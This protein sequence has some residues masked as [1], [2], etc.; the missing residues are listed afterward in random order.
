[1]HSSLRRALAPALAVVCAV[2]PT[3]ALAWN[4]EGHKQI[5]D[6]AWT[7]LRP[8]AK[9]AV[10]QILSAADGEFNAPAGDEAKAR[11]AFR[12]LATM[13]DVIKGSKESA[14]TPLAVEF[15]KT[16][17]PHPDSRNREQEL[18]KTWHYYDE[19][20][21]YSGA[22]PAI[23][24]SNAL[25]ALTKA[26][27][28]LADLSRRGDT[29]LYSSWWL[30]WIEHIVGDLHQPL[31][32]TSNY[33]KEREEGDAGGNKIHLGINGRNGRPLALHAYW[34]DGVDHAREAEGAGSR[35]AT[36]IEATTDRWS[37]DAKAQP[38]TARLRDL[39]PRDWIREGATFADKIVYSP[40]VKEGFVPSP[41][42]ESQHRELSTRQ[43]ILAGYR[44][45]EIL[46]RILDPRR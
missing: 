39:Q 38:A 43:A 21:R 46:N 12:M 14:Y 25:N 33:E 20:I 45:A 19:P 26:E 27:V 13:P 34:D 28:S 23:S 10:V 37:A 18:C 7:R 5:A 22:R 30:G 11:N 44:L 17:L 41:A 3:L 31:H 1:M 40:E 35:G 36:S 15:N 42:Y 16:W 2:A 9:A 24:E 29:S 4:A 32:C 8:K 6:I